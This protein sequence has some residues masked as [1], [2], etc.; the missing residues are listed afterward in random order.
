MSATQEIATS[1]SNA[2]AQTQQV[3]S[4]IV[5]VN[6]AAKDTDNAAGVLDMSAHALSEET[7][8]VDQLLHN[9]IIEVK[10]FEKI[11]RGEKDTEDRRNSSVASEETDPAVVAEVPTDDAAETEAE[12]GSPSEDDAAPVEDA[13]LE[14][15]AAKAA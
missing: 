15:D 5:D 9:F 14:E 3:T 12:E 6:A 1:A 10:S 7:K 8:S 11:V 13:P 2:A 4:N